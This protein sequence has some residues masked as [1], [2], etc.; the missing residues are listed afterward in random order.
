MGGGTFD[1]AM[2]SADDVTLTTAEPLTLRGVTATMDAKPMLQNVDLLANFSA[3]KRGETI[4]Y[5]VQKVEV[6]QGQTLLAA[7]S[8]TGEAKMGAKMTIAAKGNLEA[9]AA[10]LMTQPAL[11]QFATLSRGRVV[12]AFEAN[13]G[14]TTQAKAAISAKNLVAKQDNRA[15]GDLELTLT[16]N[17]KPD[18]SGT[19]TLPAHV[20]EWKSQ[21]GR[22]D[23]WCI[24]QGGE[25]GNVPLHGKDREQSAGGWTI[26]SRSPRLLRPARNR[27]PPTAPK[28]TRDTA[29][30]WKAVNG[31]VELD[32]KRVL[33]GKDYVVS[34]VRGTAV[35]TD[36]KLSLDGLE[37]KFKENAFKL[38]TAVT[39]AA[40][41]PKPY[42]L[43]VRS[44]LRGWRSAR[45]C[46][47]R[48]P[49]RSP[50]WSHE[51]RSSPT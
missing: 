18:G 34:G 21:I 32:L 17:V 25:Q 1:V 31:K 29:P 48:I 2:R 7:L 10:A 23:Q 16:A 4:T 9:D 19:I 15:L 43:P 6:K 45:S 51:C 26:F 49:M 46:A 40:Q 39:F 8:V 44:M 37:G 36:S 41:Q 28:T 33:Y 30:F 14:E 13:I 50:R 35:I 12:T 11:A 3:T 22:L 20:D 5:D 42:S 38:A 47:R 24:R 27:K